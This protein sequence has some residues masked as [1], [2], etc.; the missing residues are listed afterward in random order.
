MWHQWIGWLMTCDEFEKELA[1]GG[2]EPSYEMWRS[3]QPTSFHEYMK[4]ALERMYRQTVY[5]MRRDFEV[6]LWAGGYSDGL[7]K[8]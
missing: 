2:G 3:V 6:R 8:N 4:S 5:A 1:S 7:E